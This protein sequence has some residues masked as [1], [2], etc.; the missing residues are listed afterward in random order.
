MTLNWFQSGALLSCNQH[1]CPSKC[2]QLAD[3]SQ[4][5]CEDVSS[6]PCPNGHI[7]RW[8]CHKGP[9]PTCIQ[10]DLAQELAE[11]KRQEQF[12]L[13]E[14]RDAKQRAHER[15]MAE[16]EADLTHKRETLRYTREAEE[17]KRALAQKRM[18]VDAVTELVRAIIPL[19]ARARSLLGAPPSIISPL[20]SSLPATPLADPPIPKPQPSYTDLVSDSPL[21]SNSAPTTKLSAAK[22]EWERQKRLEGAINPPIDAIMAMTGLEDVKRQVLRI[23]T[24]VE[25]ST[26][27]GTNLKDERFNIA[28]L[29]NPGTGI[30]QTLLCYV[31]Y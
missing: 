14:Q 15:Q 24:K 31:M 5:L 4:M 6:A 29:G 28:M 3:H 22:Q 26:R 11:R 25:A 13:Q 17:R 27:Q 1:P 18:D 2:H 12:A 16:L 7:Q 19:P 9:P 23:K 21:T 20:A 8:K 30:A 10:C